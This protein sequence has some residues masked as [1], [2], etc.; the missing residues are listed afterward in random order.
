MR[1][2]QK[3][4]FFNFIFAFLPGAAEMY[5]GFMKMGA[6]LMLTF[7]GVIMM[8]GFLDLSDAFAVFIPVIWFYGFF[9]AR[10][11][12]TCTPDIFM[13]IRDD[14]FWNDFIDGKK[15]NI[16]S[17]KTRKVIAWALI[18]I[19]IATLWNMVTRPIEEAFLWMTDSPIARYLHGAFE[20]IP[21]LL[22]ALLIIFVGLKMINGKKKELF[23]SDITYDIAASRNTNSYSNNGSVAHNFNAPSTPSFNQTAPGFNKPAQDFT[24]KAP[25]APKMPDFST[26]PAPA[27]PNCSVNAPEAPKAP[28]TPINLEFSAKVSTDTPDINSGEEKKEA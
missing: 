20:S 28:E 17:E 14:F 21:K 18:I 26:P 5:M 22:I 15:I 23:I 8:I 25:E 3:R 11:L 16:Q 10:N 27:A 1:P 19:G 7:F 4:G 12:A 24:I 13:S 6:S 9:H 2:R